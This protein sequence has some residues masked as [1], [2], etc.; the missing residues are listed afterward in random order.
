LGALAAAVERALLVVTNDTGVSHAAAAMRT[1]SVVVV[2]GSDPERWA[3]HDRQL[4]EIV[5]GRLDCRP[6]PRQVCPEERRCGESVTVDNVLAAAHRVINRTEGRANLS[7]PL[8]PAADE[9]LQQ[10]LMGGPAC[11]A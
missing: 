4:H 9:R 5:S 3:P 10:S 8:E 1:P 2:L 6:C 11:V 7:E